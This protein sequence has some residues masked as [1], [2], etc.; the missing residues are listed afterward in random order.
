MSPALPTPSAAHPESPERRAALSQEIMAAT[1]LDEATLERL[2]RAFY[3]TAR[4][5]ALIGPMFARVHDWETHIATI[6][7]FWSSVALM[8]GSYHG[9]PMRA[10]APLDLHKPHFARWLALFEATATGICTPQGV[11]YLME[12]AQRIAQSMEFAHAVLRGELPARG[13]A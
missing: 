2:V 7:R 10:H 6:T 8:T 5:D 3:A 1:G 4:Q 9:Q 12:K 13:I 11:A